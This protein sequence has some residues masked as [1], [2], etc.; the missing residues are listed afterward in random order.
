MRRSLPGSTLIR[1]AL[2]AL[3]AGGAAPARA[4]LD[5]ED[6][7]PALHNGVIQLRVTNAGILGNAFFAVGRSTDPSFEHPPGSGREALNYAS[8]WVGGRLEDGTVHVSGGS[9]LEFR[10]TPDP[11]DRVRLVAANERRILRF[12]DDDNDGRVDEETLDGRDE[13]GDG[14]VDE[15]LGLF[16]QQMAAAQYV[17][18]RPE[19]VAYV[20]PGGEVHRPL[21]VSVRQ[22]VFGWAIPGYDRAAGVRWVITN[23]SGRLLRDVY[24]GL[25][26][27][28][29]SRRRENAIGHLD[30]RVEELGYRRT[31]FTG[32]A[33]PTDPAECRRPDNTIVFPTG[34]LAGRVHAVADRDST[35]GL[36]FAAFLPLSHTTDP[37]AHF[38]HRF[39]QPI[40]RAPAAIGFRSQVFEVNVPPASG[41]PPLTDAGRYAALADPAPDAGRARGRHGDWA[42]LVS[43]GPF[44]RLD[45]GQSLEINGALLA[46]ASRETL[47]AQ[48]ENLALIEHGIRFNLEP[49]D[50]GTPSEWMFHGATGI[51]G[52]EAC[53]RPPGGVTLVA[54]PH[55]LSKFEEPTLGEQLVV[56]PPD[57]CLWTD[58][59]CNACTG[60]GGYDAAYR[61]M[62]PGLLPPPPG[63][64]VVPLDRGVR[65]EWD[66]YPEVAIR[67]DVHDWGE[68]RFIGYR[69]WKVA[70]WHDRASL[71]P[72]L[73]RW[74]LALNAG[75]DPETG[76]VPLAAHTDSTLEPERLLYERPLY[77]VGRYAWEDREVLNGFD[78]AYFVS[79]VYEA[80]LRDPAGF[81]HTRKV[82]SPIQAG[83]DR[84]VSPR[85]AAAARSG[86]V[87]VVPNPY[88]GAAPWDRRPVLG[89]A[90]TSH[91]DFVGLPRAL[92][93][94][95]IWTV[96]GD[97]VADVVHDGRGGS[98]Q[99]PWN[100][101]TRNGQ[102]V[103]SGIY[104]FTVDSPLGRQT[105][106]FVVIR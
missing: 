62:A 36:P 2:P 53:L 82:V 77:P 44:S 66:N 102:D 30:D 93:R 20:Y 52:H 35:A 48:M 51:H 26:A 47:L 81:L 100:L 18:D 98:G 67:S 8:L 92:C 73:D 12:H 106:R 33:L 24:V 104:V 99:A 31:I 96:A 42:V 17:D 58:A 54:D 84:R 29:D 55:C 19:A 59:D 86:S 88:R 80:R 101:V 90:P 76:A 79:S 32:G 89:D 71:M 69:V 57:R 105:G 50:P 68:T 85:G 40:S 56:Y 7:G 28:L 103:A 95:T 63:M 22:E 13:D 23:H 4:V 1:L 83:F 61:W 43:C 91:L 16:S 3:L 74:S 70:D 38:D 87:R 46:S 15:D 94:I 34:V 49:D 45:P 11:A 27:D 9:L 64:R 78:Y 21:G 5:I 39:S 41:G 25:Y 10:P 97:R 14:E 75:D 37:L 6:R 60:I 72:D 65:V